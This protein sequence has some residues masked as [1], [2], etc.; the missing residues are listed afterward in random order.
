MSLI[1]VAP[2]K[3][4]KKHNIS[5]R[6]SDCICEPEVLVEGTDEVGKPARVFIHGKVFAE[7]IFLAQ[8]RCKRP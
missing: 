1:H 4:R 6:G 7:A 2:V 5:G 8:E 3:H